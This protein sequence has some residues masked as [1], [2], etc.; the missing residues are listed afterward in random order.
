MASK[1]LYSMA[2]NIIQIVDL[3]RIVSISMEFLF[4]N[5]NFMHGLR[6]RLQLMSE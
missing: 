2:C 6:L 1:I 4:I 5:F 3:F